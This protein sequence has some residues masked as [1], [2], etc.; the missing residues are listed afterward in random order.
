MISKPRIWATLM[1]NESYLPGTIALAYSLSIHKTAYPLLILVTPTLPTSC[2][3]VLKSEAVHNPLIQIQQVELL[4]P[5]CQENNNQVSRFKDTWTKLR[6]FELTTYDTIVYLDADT[7]VF[8]NPDSIFDTPL[9]TSDYLAAI[10]DC[11]CTLRNGRDDCPYTSMSHPTALSHPAPVPLSSV[12][13]RK[14][15]D[16]VLN[17]GVFVFKPSTRLSQD[18]L[19][20]F[21]TSTI[22]ST[23]K[24]PDQDFLADFA[25]TPFL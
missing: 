9:P 12:S 24:A 21:H 10:H 3:E 1:T 14:L 4:Q 8:Q 13:D 6:V 18:I 20:A 2:L 15:R 25:S 17:S 11:T 19:H 16:T 5:T 7:L 23:Y 22:L